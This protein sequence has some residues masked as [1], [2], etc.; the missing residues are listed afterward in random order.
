[1]R[2]TPLPASAFG[3]I[4]SGE[5]N[6][7]PQTDQAALETHRVTHPKMDFEFPAP[8]VGMTWLVGRTSLVCLTSPVCMTWLV[9]M[10]SLVGLT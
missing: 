2:L 3:S 7:A 9:G 1:M 4:A 6:A 8:L 10:T 5:L